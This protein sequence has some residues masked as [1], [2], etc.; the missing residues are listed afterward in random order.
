[1]CSTDQ[2][3]GR[4]SGQLTID[5]DVE[6]VGPG[7]ESLVI[8]GN[9]TTSSKRRVFY[10]D[11]GVEAVISG[12]SITG[13]DANTGN[14]GGI[15]SE[16]DL[17]LSNVRIYENVA[18]E[19][20]GVYFTGGSLT[21]LRSSITD[22]EA[23]GSSG[24]YGGIYAGY[25]EE[26]IIDSSTIA[27]NEAIYVGGIGVLNTES[28]I[29]NSTISSNVA[30]DGYG[31]GLFYYSD[32]AVPTTLTNVT[33]A[34]NDAGSHLGGGIY[35]EPNYGNAIE[36]VLRNS[37][38][39]DNVNS[40]GA[41]DVY[42]D[43][44][45]SSSYNVIGNG[46]DTNLTDGDAGNQIGTASSPL[47]P[48]LEALGDYGGPTETH[49]LQSDSP[50]L[51]A[52]SNALA[53]AIDYDQ[54]GL[55]RI[56]DA[57]VDV[58]ALETISEFIVLSNVDEA[59]GDYRN[60]QFSLRETLHLASLIPGSQQIQFDSSLTD[61]IID[62]DGEL[63]HLVVN[64]D[65]VIEGLGRNSL[66][67]KSSYPS[68][69]F[70]IT[71]GVEVEIRNVTI[72][73]GGFKLPPGNWGGGILNAGD[74]TLRSVLIWNHEAPVGGAIAQEGSGA[75]L[76]L[77]DSIVYRNFASVGAG[78][79]IGAGSVQIESSTVDSNFAGLAGG[80]VFLAPSTSLTVIDSTISNNGAAASGG[81]VNAGTGTSVSLVNS[82]ISGNIREGLRT[83]GTLTALNSTI[84]NNSPPLSDG[85]GGITALSS[86][87]VLLTNTI[88]AAN[89]G[90]DISGT[91]NTSSSYNL[92]GNGDEANLTNGGTNHIGT[93]LSSIDP[94]LLILGDY[95]GPTRT[96]A[97]QSGSLAIDH[98]SNS[99]ASGL[100]YD[101]R[102]LGFD[103]VIDGG[104]AS[105]V[106]IGAF[107]FDPSNPA[108]PDFEDG[109][110]G[111]LQ[112]VDFTD[113]ET[114]RRSTSHDSRLWAFVESYSHDASAITSR[115]RGRVGNESL[116]LMD[117]A[118]SHESLL[119]SHALHSQ[120]S[121]IASAKF[122]AATLRLHESEAE[123]VQAIDE[124]MEILGGDRLWEFAGNKR[125]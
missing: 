38:V 2:E 107:E 15:L 75:N 68:R 67:I 98:G 62:L 33:I 104:T 99:A 70:F 81:G 101:Q 46:D 85:A 51:N 97:L 95:G 25:A 24:T 111:F 69:A 116:P 17:T 91:F 88:V 78:L 74:L 29:T 35:V 55:N 53:S 8:D 122:E 32:V 23:T 110:G 79:Y 59:D 5:S 115:G 63:G 114:S 94:K 123:D 50:A 48:K 103:R 121:Q 9:S 3:T 73:G 118:S 72:F 43:L 90:G 105:V 36:I 14:G 113:A 77:I 6:I 65:V 102:G 1:M 66:F 108:E 106:D 40:G 109:S 19:G 7:D 10:V 11:A 20:G 22:N 60:S 83:N 92:I 41:D 28:A 124:C 117:W 93:A 71:S 54:R 42:G 82:T 39:A 26:L 76:H 112:T 96:H 61:Q 80:G 4:R 52:G 37:I 44:D 56:S 34:D 12:L 47:D 100:S 64:S 21:V 57:T 120:G 119:I 16:G 31:G 87:S 18:N 30:A 49:Y 89:A 45:A 27:R 58:G 13:G 84:A 86:S 125:S